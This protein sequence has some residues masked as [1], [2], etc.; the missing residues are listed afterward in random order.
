MADEKKESTRR[1]GTTP[2]LEEDENAP[3]ARRSEGKS[4]KYRVKPGQSITLGETDDNGEPVQRVYRAGAEVS[5]TEEQ[6]K[7]M[8]WAVEKGDRRSRSGQT[9]RLSKRVKEL[10]AEIERLQADSKTR[11]KEDPHREAAI[12]SL[13]ARGDNFIGRGEPQIGS[14]PPEAADL[15]DRALAEA[16]FGRNTLKSDDEESGMH[17]I[18][19]A[20]ASDEELRLAGPQVGPASTPSTGGPGSGNAKDAK[21]PEGPKGGLNEKGEPNK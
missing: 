14:V 13:K 21:D 5:L 4:A 7:A 2:V 19:R 6:A 8:P 18:A 3:S 10:E 9:S 11:S 15:H 1:S 20:R 17:G 12:S 16:E